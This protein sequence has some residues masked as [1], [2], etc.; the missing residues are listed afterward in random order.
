MRNSVDVL[1]IGAGIAGASVA[2]ALAR[3]GR[4]VLVIARGSGIGEASP[5][6]AGMLAA[7]IEAGDLQ[8]LPLAL[9][10]RRQH[11]ELAR[12]LALAGA[13]V[14]LAGGG[15]VQLALDATRAAA[16]AAIAAAASAPG[17]RTTWLSASDV[18][19]ELPGLSGDVA[20]ALIAE[21]DGRVD[22]VALLRALVKDAV[23]AGAMVEYAAAEML[24]LDNGVV[25]GA[26]TS[27]GERRADV[28]VL[29]AGAWSGAIKGL[30]RPLPVEPVR[31]QIVQTAWPDPLPRRILFGPD[32]YVV[33]RGDTALL[34]S[35]MERAG[36][37]ARTTREGIAAIRSGAG[38]FVPAL[39]DA[40]VLESWA[41]LRPMTP[42]SRPIL[43]AD[44]DVPGLYYCTGHGRNGILL[45]PLTGE[46]V[47]QL[48]VGGESTWDLRP[49]G[50]ERFSS[51]DPR[52]PTPDA[53]V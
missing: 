31:G 12:E 53:H 33:P 47:A 29:A 26:R 36:F 25:Q 1:V 8:M 51:S 32:A 48:I 30:P 7:Q 34:G 40:P 6:A 38:A 44:P 21:G 28:V 22:N 4:K 3:G 2:R 35:T 20:G 45:G 42:D 14:A 50:V 41:G 49:Y 5:A 23:K 52:S 16:L 19:R 18:R 17:L 9:A 43:G 10:A 13:S 27:S 46:I 24:L 15:I 11:E 39:A 37:D